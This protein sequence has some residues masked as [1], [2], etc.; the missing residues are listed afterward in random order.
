M[1]TYTVHRLHPEAGIA[2]DEFGRAFRIPA[3]LEDADIAYYVQTPDSFRIRCGCRMG[4]DETGLY[5]YE[6]ALE[7]ELRM[8]EVGTEGRAWCDSCLEV[9]M[10]PDIRRPELYFNCECT[11]KPCVHLA[12][13]GNGRIGRRQFH[14][15]PEGLTPTPEIL[16]GYGWSIRYRIP[17]TFLQQEFDVQVLHE[18]MEMRANFQKCGDETRVPHWAL[19]NEMTPCENGNYD[20]HRPQF[21]G[22]LV[23]AE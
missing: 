12:V 11:P 14:T 1:K 6:Y 10:A 19:W 15:L 13:G 2:D 9:F 21:F 3:G 16:P 17:I 18:G 7:T 22:R 4:W 5:V 23:L 8:E 20:F